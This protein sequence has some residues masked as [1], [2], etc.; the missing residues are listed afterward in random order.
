MDFAKLYPGPPTNVRKLRYNRE[1]NELNQ[2]QKIRAH[3]FLYLPAGKKHKLAQNTECMYVVL[4]DRFSI[5][6]KHQK[7][8]GDELSVY[9]FRILRV[10]IIFIHT[11]VADKAFLLKLQRYA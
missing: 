10:S 2:M 4:K 9:D 11:V 7:G 5:R 6:S 3:L 1:Q 8:R